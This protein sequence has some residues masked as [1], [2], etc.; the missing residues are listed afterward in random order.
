MILLDTNVISE[1]MLPEPDERI[2]RWLDRQPAASIWTT[3]VTVFEIR[4]GLET[5]PAGKRRTTPSAFFE[6]WLHEAM[7]QRI[8]SYDET[9]AHRAAELASER[10]KEDV[11]GNSATQ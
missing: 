2:I 11:Q 6:Q 9:A 5:M 8:V 1:I 3:S 7:Q 10:Q 4:F